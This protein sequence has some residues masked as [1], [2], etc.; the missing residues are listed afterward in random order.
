MVLSR[1]M[2][3]K[4]LAAGQTYTHDE[5]KAQTEQEVAD[6]PAETWRDGVFSFGDYL[7][8]SLHSGTITFVEDL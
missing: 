4:Y 1:G 3:T 8:E 5:L 7:T 2:A 6:L